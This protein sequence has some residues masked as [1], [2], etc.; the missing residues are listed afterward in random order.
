MKKVLVLGAGLVTQPLV[1]YLLEQPEIELIVASRTVSKA[2][3]LIENHPKGKAI[4]LNV[5]DDVKLEEL[6]IDSVVT[7]SLLPYTYHVKVAKL[8]LKHGVNLVTTSYVSD[9]MNELNDEAKE[10]GLLLL[11]EIGLDPGIDHMSAMKIIHDVE[12]N[13]GKI[14]S[15]ES[16]CGGL[17]APEANDN[18]FGYKFSW[19]PRGVVMAGRN[20]ARYLKDGIEKSIEGKDL[21]KNHWNK[22]VETLGTLEVYPNRDSMIYKPLYQLN[23]AETIFRGT[24]RNPGWCSTLLNIAK[25]GYLDDTERPE[26]ADKT[27]AEVAAKLI[28]TDSPDSIKS[29][30]A[31]H[32]GIE[33]DSEIIKRFEWLGLL[34]DE[35]IDA[36]PVTYLDI[37]ANRML[38]MMPYKKGERDMIVLQH[39]FIAE[40]DGNKKEHITSL[41]IDFGIPNGDSAMA[42]TVSLPAAIATKLIVDGKINITGVQVP[43]MPEI[44]EP[45]LD[46]LEKMNIKF[47]ETKEV[48]G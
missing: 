47:K 27:F 28:G 42:R 40:Y 32:L 16:V 7:I 46:E 13:G 22:D 17:P 6:V 11:N 34:S 15:F 18:P 19:S 23:D 29:K 4:E 26:L 25:L 41:L 45:L 9:A 12:K 36:D 8:C 1:R 21:F 37:L 30:V 5:K 24:F 10:K 31:D 44:Y 43:V 14:V 35:K 39:D 3:A 33:A 48:L 38:K 2:V 20:N